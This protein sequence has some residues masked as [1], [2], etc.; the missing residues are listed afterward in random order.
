MI[1]NCHVLWVSALRRKKDRNVTL[2]PF[3]FVAGD[4]A[5]NDIATDMRDRLEQAGFKADA[6]MTGL[7]EM[8]GIQQ[9]FIDH[10][11]QGLDEKP[12]S[13]SQLK[14]KFLSEQ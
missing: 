5:H 4:H 2:V 9:I 11:R 8:P 12:L 3:M 14:R 10:I 6:V 7:G 1:I 13:P